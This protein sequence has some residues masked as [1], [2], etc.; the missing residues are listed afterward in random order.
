[1][2]AS[3]LS[4]FIKAKCQDRLDELRN[5]RLAHKFVIPPRNLPFRERVKGLLESPSKIALV[6]LHYVETLSRRRRLAQSQFANS[7]K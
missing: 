3:V 7:N 5:C 2:N 4:R 6:I 1:M